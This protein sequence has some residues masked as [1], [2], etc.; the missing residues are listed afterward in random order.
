MSQ[1]GVDDGGVRGKCRGGTGGRVGSKVVWD[2]GVGVGA[3]LKNFKKELTKENLK[4]KLKVRAGNQRPGGLGA[5]LHGMYKQD[6]AHVPAYEMH[7][8]T[9]YLI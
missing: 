5:N 8:N 9:R 3:E 7:L 2:W 4:E 6:P 1:P